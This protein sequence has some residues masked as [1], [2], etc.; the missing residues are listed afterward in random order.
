VTQTRPGDSAKVTVLVAVEPRV[1]FDVFTEEIDLWWRRGP[2]YRPSTRLPG[3]L[4]LEPGV[5]GRLFESAGDGPDTRLFE[6]GRVLVWDPPARLVLE[7]RGVHFAPGEKTEI[8]VRFDASPSGTL[9]TLEH[10]GW[11]S[12]REDHPARHGLVGGAFSRMIGRWWGDLM[13]SLREHTAN[14]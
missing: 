9:V 10:R 6:V 7:W 12:L 11:A 14:R 2:K 13:T 3:V 8:D 4:R 1:A 5:G